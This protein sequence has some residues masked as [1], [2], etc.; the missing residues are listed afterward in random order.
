MDD[1]A[2]I[3]INR[4]I[5]GLLAILCL[6]AGLAIGVTDSMENLW[7][8]SFVRAGL[9]LAA[10]WIA[11]PTKGRAAAWAQTSPYWI[12]LIV[13][14]LIVIRRLEIFLLAALI[15]FFLAVVVPLLI[16]TSKRN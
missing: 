16:G 8:G 13:G 4:L 12:L 9:L 3:R 5:V 15:L 1:T 11:M 14:G 7:C 6:I 10:F 2:R